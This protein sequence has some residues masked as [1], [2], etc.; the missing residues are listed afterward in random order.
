[1][2][3]C[4]ADVTA[5]AADVVAVAAEAEAIDADDPA[6]VADV[7]ALDADVDALAADAFTFVSRDDNEIHV[8]VEVSGDVISPMSLTRPE[9]T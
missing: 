9:A 4:A 8:P 5:V 6:E 3:A 7:N 1:M 2:E